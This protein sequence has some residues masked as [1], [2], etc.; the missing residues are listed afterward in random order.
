MQSTLRILGLSVG[1][2]ANFACSGESDTNNREPQFELPQILPERTPLCFSYSDTEVNTPRTLTLQVTNEGRQQL[3]IS[4]ARKEGDE[5]EHFTIEGPD[6]MV[7]ESLE[8]A[9]FQ[10][11]YQPT[12]A[13]WDDFIVIIDSNAQNYPAL[14]VSVLAR[15]VP[16]AST[17]DGGVESWD[18]GPKP[19]NPDAAETCPGDSARM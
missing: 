18:A 13:G 8:S 17:L 10:I 12:E 2:C 5:R 4:G 15:A 19:G 3:V 6:V 7:V 1:L 16:E 11:T 14:R 9:L